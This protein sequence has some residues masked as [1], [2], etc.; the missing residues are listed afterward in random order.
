[1]DHQ[2][3]AVGRQ[4]RKL[5]EDHGLSQEEFAAKA[6][7]DRAYYGAVERGKRNLSARN[8]IKI[9]VALNV[10]VGALFPPISDLR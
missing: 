1:V 5:R 4:I 10:D 6:G 2:L 8:L 7:L 3:E 9:A